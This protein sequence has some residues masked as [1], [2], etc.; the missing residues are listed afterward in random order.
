MKKYQKCEINNQAAQTL[1]PIFLR[2][3]W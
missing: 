2:I 1:V 3:F